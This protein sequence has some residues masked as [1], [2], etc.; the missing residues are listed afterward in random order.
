MIFTFVNGYN[1]KI[2]M[3]K[4]I[5]KIKMGKGF[6]ETLHQRDVDGKQE[7]KKDSLNY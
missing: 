2:K 1:K 3:K 6:E 4:K 7:H 5:N